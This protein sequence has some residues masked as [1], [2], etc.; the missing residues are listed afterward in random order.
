MTADKSASDSIYNN[1]SINRMNQSIEGLYNGKTLIYVNVNE[2]FDDGNRNLAAG[3]TNDQV[4]VL[5][6][7]QAQWADWLDSNDI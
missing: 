6:K 4:H 2:L 1:D 5:G 3:Y 7:Y